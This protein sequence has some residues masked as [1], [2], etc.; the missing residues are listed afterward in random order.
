MRNNAYTNVMV[1][2]IAETA[3]KVLGILP[4]SR[5]EALSD[6]LGLTADEIT[7]GTR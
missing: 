5:R 2:W 4:E 7:R 3:V 6:R 1:A